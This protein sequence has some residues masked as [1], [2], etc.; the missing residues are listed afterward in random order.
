M[1]IQESLEADLFAPPM[2]CDQDTDGAQKE[3]GNEACT[4]ADVPP[5]LAEPMID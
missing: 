2:V 3:S 5:D 4:T 1:I